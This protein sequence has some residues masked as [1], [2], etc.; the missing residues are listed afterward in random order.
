MNRKNISSVFKWELNKH[1]KSPVFLLFTFL[2][3]A[4]MLVAGILPGFLASQIGSSEQDLW[5]LDE[6]GQLEQLLESSFSESRYNLEIVEGSPDQ[7][8]E[9]IEAGEADALLHITEQSLT[10]GQMQIYCQDTMNLS[11]GELE[12]LL[13]P[14]LTQYRLQA[15]GISPEEFGSLLV[16][17]SL[18]MYSLSGEEDSVVTFLIP[19]VLGFFLFMAVM[20]SGQIMMQSVIKEKRNRV[21]EILLSS[22]S[23]SELLAGKILAFGVLA[24][25]Q[26]GLWLG[27]GLAAATR[28]MDL[29]EL[30]LDAGQLLAA[31][32][33]FILGYLLFATI[34]AAT[35]ATM[36]DAE[37][38]SQAHGLVIMI[39][40]LPLM[41]ATPIMM[42]PEGVFSRI[43]SYIPIFTPATMLLRLGS[44]TVPIWELALTSLILLVS[45]LFFLRI[46]AR[47]YQGSLLKFD[48]AASF[49]DI[50]KMVKRK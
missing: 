34:F 26:T 36:K 33:Y 30:G 43:I 24:L 16:P 3:P 23:A 11:R 20:F 50:A 46:G 40:L 15:S 48:S 22:V 28:F 32:P 1:I 18:Q 42:A 37:S 17:P 4:I 27:T 45:T 25:V 38:G 44:G 9:D 5:V 13:Q 12:Q 8:K 7:L 35:A 39:P 21:I 10:D 6:S 31:M 47:I 19:L 14:A 2:I 49:K 41:L 29:G